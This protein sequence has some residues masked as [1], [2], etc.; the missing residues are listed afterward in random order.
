MLVR[1]VKISLSLGFLENKEQINPAIYP[2]IYNTLSAFILQLFPRKFEL[3]VFHLINFF[4]FI[5][6]CI[7]RLQSFKKS[8]LTR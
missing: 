4:C 2:A 6:S 3:E 8:Y 7:W 1:I 5:L